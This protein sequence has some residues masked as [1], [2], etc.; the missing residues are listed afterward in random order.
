MQ[1]TNRPRLL[2]P[3][4]LLAQAPG[5]GPH[6]SRNGAVLRSNLS[7]GELRRIVADLLG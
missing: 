1:L 6:L 5:T 2:P 3:L 4:A 7:T